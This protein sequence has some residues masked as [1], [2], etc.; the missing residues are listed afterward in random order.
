MDQLK[1]PY[2]LIRDRLG[3]GKVI[4]FLG[5]GASLSQRASD[6]VWNKD[7]ADCLPTATELARHLAQKSDFPHD[8]PPNLPDDLAPR[9]L[10]HFGP[11]LAKVAQYYHIVGGRVPLED[12]LHHIFDRDYQPG[13][14]HAYLATI[15]TPILIVTTNYDDLIERAFDNTRRAY[16]VVIHT[17]YPEETDRI[18]WWRF[19][20]ANPEPVMPDKLNIDLQATPV[21]YKIHGTVDRRDA[22]RDQY[23]ITEDDYIDFLARMVRGRAIPKIFA[24]PFSIRNFL[25]LG[26]GLRDWNMRVVWNRIE[27]GLKRD[28]KRITS[29]AIQ[30]K[31]SPLERRFWQEHRVE[32]YE[33]TVDD[34]VKKLVNGEG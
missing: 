26:Y 20:A 24:E 13:S 33:M 28:P 27:R 9:I 21:I 8:L 15:Q 10:E 32:T 4:P 25:F 17:T 30:H 22:K 29:W 1:P 16:D 14:L 31:I 3:E 34:F 12:A 18:L 7:C 5:S 11:D 23:V 6:F 19:G 2:T